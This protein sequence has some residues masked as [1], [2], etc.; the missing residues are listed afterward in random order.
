MKT[1]SVIFFLAISG[2]V[3]L[4]LAASHRAGLYLQWHD[5]FFNLSRVDVE[6]FQI[7]KNPS[8]DQSVALIKLTPRSAKKFHQLTEKAKGEPIA[9]V[10]DGRIIA[11]GTLHAPLEADL[12]IGP[13]TAQEAEQVRKT[14]EFR[15][16]E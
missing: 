16:E 15:P 3:S 2:F 9:W 13:F 7:A 4:A 14:I 10:W 8:S 1:M 11:L 6:Q 5:Q 12:T